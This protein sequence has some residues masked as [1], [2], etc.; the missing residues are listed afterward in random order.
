MYFYPELMKPS[1]WT[2]QLPNLLVPLN[3]ARTWV[4]RGVESPDPRQGLDDCRR[5]IRLGRLLRQEDEVIITDLLGLACI[6][7]GAQ[8]MYDIAIREGDAELAVLASIVI[9]EVAPQRLLTSE[10]ITRTWDDS[11]LRR[12]AAGNFEL[13]VPDEKLDAILELAGDQMDRRFRGEAILQLNLVRFMGT[14]SQQERVT[15]LLTELRESDDYMVSE[16]ARWSLETEPT[17][18]MLEMLKE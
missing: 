7:M 6:R 18:E 12:D 13:A 10:R 16:I 2:T 14:E 9:G 3:F 5:A 17:P 15:S 11:F 1:G 4:A 8:G